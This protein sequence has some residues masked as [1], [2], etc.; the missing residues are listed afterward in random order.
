MYMSM[1]EGHGA[2]HVFTTFGRLL[3]EVDCSI[4]YFKNISTNTSGIFEPVILRGLSRSTINTLEGFL[5][6]MKI[7]PMNLYIC[8]YVLESEFL[9]SVCASRYGQ[10]QCSVT[11][12]E[13]VPRPSSKVLCKLTNFDL[14]GLS[15]Q[16]A[17][18]RL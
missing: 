12:H 10:P 6:P 14:K 7:N 15:F 9:I 16:Q 3:N 17:I 8:P 4:I 2:G 18:S 5:N 1:V 11:K 13:I